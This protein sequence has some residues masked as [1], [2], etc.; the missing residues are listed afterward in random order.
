MNIAPNRPTGHTLRRRLIIVL[1]LTTLLPLSLLGVVSYLSIRSIL[2]HNVE[3]G[4]RD[5]LKQTKLNLENAFNNLEYI[6]LQLTAQGSVGEQLSTKDP[7]EQYQTRRNIQNNLNLINFTNPYI[8]VMLYYLPVTGQVLYQNLEVKEPFKPDMNAKLSA[9]AGEFLY[10]PHRSSYTYSDKL[11]FSLIRSVH[12]SGSDA[13]QAYIYLETSLKLLEDLLTN[14]QNGMPASY[15][16]FNQDGKL[17]FTNSPGRYAPESQPINAG[18][19]GS[20]KWVDGYYLI[21]ETSEQGWSIAIAIKRNDLEHE[22]V[23]W[24][25]KYGGIVFVCLAVS[26]VLALIVWRMVYVPLMAIHKEIRMMDGDRLSL[27]TRLTGISEFDF[28]LFEFQAARKRIVELFGEVERRERDKAILEVE[29]LVYQINPHFIH[30]T[31]NTIQW[32]ARMN[33]QPEIDRLVSAFTRVLH[34]NLGKEGGIVPLRE[35]IAALQDYI[36][37]QRIRYDYEFNIGCSFDEEA[38]NIYVP[39]FILQPLVENALYHGISDQDGSIT[40]RINLQEERFVAIQIDDNGEGMTQ[41]QVDRMLQGGGERLKS[42]LGIG[43]R[44]VLRILKAYYS[45][46]Y[47]FNIDSRIGKGTS[48]QLLLP[49]HI[50]AKGEIGRLKD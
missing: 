19:I 11:V 5:G 32:L 45:D 47:Q 36:E 15:L 30:N 23:K 12:T 39:R 8:G 10:G 41:E 31:L 17:V 42:G 38:C 49:I 6:S 43:L 28:V 26:L 27:E 4:I 37:L 33:G 35:E 29:K 3:S 40:V 48:I 18:V 46:S 44:Y 20:G 9:T 2:T 13:P 16:L 24:I 21:R 50:P 14:S 22:Y 7:F 1:L 25:F 34:Y